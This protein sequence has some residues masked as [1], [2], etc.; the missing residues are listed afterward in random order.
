[1]TGMAVIGGE[2]LS[3]ANCLGFRVDRNSFNT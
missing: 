2:E 3:L 1:M